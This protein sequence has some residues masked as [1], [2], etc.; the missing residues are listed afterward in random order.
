MKSF[1]FGLVIVPI[2]TFQ[3]TAPVFAQD[4][5][6]NS[7]LHDISSY[8]NQASKAAVAQQRRLADVIAHADTMI[9]QRITSLNAVTQRIQS[10]TRL[11]SDQKTNLLHDIQS[12]ITGLTTLKTKIDADTDA[13]TAY[14]DEKQIISSYHVYATL[15]PK[16]H[17]LLM[18]N[19]VQSVSGRLQTMAP[20]LQSIISS[21][22]SQ[23]K[24]ISQLTPLM[25]DINT[26]LQTIN[27]LVTTDL[28][29][30]QSIQ[31]TTEGS[32]TSFSKV[33]SD[34][35]T[36]VHTGFGSIIKDITQMR[37]IF[38]QLILGI[39]PKPSTANSGN[40]LLPRTLPTTAIISPT[41]GSVL[42]PTSVPTS[43][44]SGTVQK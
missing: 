14:T 38:Q 35:Q 13:Q 3:M 10:D 42:S 40:P 43:T 28:A 27:T 32:Q 8:Q 24:D 1:V 7:L 25:N 16:F 2:I 20:Q 9:T 41:S 30:I 21:F 34:M 12:V 37:P 4:L 17:Y 18:L 29:S 11:T 36:T 5:G 15:E 19:N 6:A 31:I 22:Q 33:K 23:G 39:S 26:Q 44:S